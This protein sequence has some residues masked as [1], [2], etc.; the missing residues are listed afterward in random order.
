MSAAPRHKTP[1]RE[2]WEK[3]Q[4]ALQQESDGGGLKNLKIEVPKDPEVNPE[5]YRDVEPMLYQG[6]ITQLATI[7]DVV[8]AF[9]SINHHEYNLLRLM[10]VFEK[11]ATHKLWDTL[12]AYNVL[13]V[14]GQNILLDRQRLLP[15][16]TK[17]F[18]DMEPKAK[19]LIIRHMSEINRRANNALLLTECYAMESYSR[20]R[21]MQLRGL[22]F[23]QPV[24]T[25]IPGTDLLGMNWAQLTW[26][27]LNYLDDRNDELEREWENAKFV[28][29][30]F[31]GK[32]I[33][34]I[35]DQDNERRR[36]EKEDRFARKDSILRRV[37]LGEKPT[38]K[39]RQLNGAVLTTAH[40][41]EDLAHQL[42]SDLKGEKDW[43]DKVVEEHERRIKVNIQGRQEQVRELSERH[44]KEFQG[45]NIVGGTD[46]TGL[47]AQQVQ[48]RI[49]RRKQLE[50]Q[51]NAQRMVRPAAIVE[52]EK[53]MQFLDRWG[54][55][56]NEVGF[57]VGTS[58]R[59]PSAAVPIAPP[60]QGG[61]PFGRK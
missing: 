8:F 17:V 20:Y 23:C 58:D 4:L 31:A 32:G 37:L 45:Q 47:T 55:T 7:G 50:A 25:G 48:E 5:V 54:I 16:V 12:L 57:S 33:Q 26:R 24:V 30:C 22:D 9:K 60:K 14:D 36:K 43:H 52:D 6:F 56:N 61:T 15:G 42:E 49:Q 27:A 28:G 44:E 46:F 38:E 19:Q 21:W 40:S 59:D 10:G 3:E 18:G 35:Y 34:K 39:V 2:Q 11:G 1:A 29:S 51:Q 13:M 41:V 53:S